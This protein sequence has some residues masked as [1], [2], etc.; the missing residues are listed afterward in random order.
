MPERETTSSTRA[1]EMFSK[2]SPSMQKLKL[3]KEQKTDVA[4]VEL[5]PDKQLAT[6]ILKRIEESIGQR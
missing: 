2:S 1:Y 3:N 6:E 4:W 5:Q